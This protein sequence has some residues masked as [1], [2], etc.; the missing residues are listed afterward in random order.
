MV[1]GDVYKDANDNKVMFKELIFTV[2]DL[3]GETMIR[4]YVLTSN[5]E[6]NQYS[7]YYNVDANFEDLF[8]YLTEEFAE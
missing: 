6:S 3:K 1:N 8:N 4:A 2:A 5:D 7:Y